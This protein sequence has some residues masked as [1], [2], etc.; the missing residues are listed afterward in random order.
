MEPNDK[1]R[2]LVVMQYL[3]LNFPERQVDGN[4][5]QSYF[6]DLSDH[7]IEN[8]EKAAKAY[9]KIGVRFPYVSDLLHFLFT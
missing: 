4:L 6:N 7:G 3:N 2:F 1:S 5:V 9:V 8:V